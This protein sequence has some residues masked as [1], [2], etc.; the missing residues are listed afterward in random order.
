MKAKEKEKEELEE[1]KIIKV[2][3]KKEDIKKKE[4]DKMEEETNIYNNAKT[5]NYGDLVIIYETGDSIKYFTLEKG[6]RFQNK[7]GV[8]LHDD[9]Y[10]KNYG[11]KIYDTKEKKK[12]ISILSF[13]PNIWERC[14]NKMTQI[15]FN[16]DISLIMILLNISQ[17]SII[18]ESGTGSG[19]LSVNMSS[20]LSK[21]SGHLYT[22]EFNKE[23]A[24]K[25]KDL[26][27][28]LNLDKKITIT[29]RDVIQDG[30]MLDDKSLA[31]P[32]HKKCGSM[33]I[34]LPSPWLA[35]VHAK[36][37]MKSGAY[38][39]SFSPCI[40]QVNQTMKAMKENNF[41]ELR[42]FEC[43]YRTFSFAR[44][45]QVKMPV[46]GKRKKG[47]KIEFKDVDINITKNKCDM[48][49]HTGFLLFG[50]NKE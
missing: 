4:N 44:T 11:C 14:L 47:E 1:N 19:C 12:Y 30:F 18:Y 32:S 33:F 8:F 3:V 16:P 42:M 34:D 5:I 10:G 50:I 35:I 13:V 41:I 36:K 9:I 46:I 23:R 31:N 17:S 29:H 45:T 15:L 7:F 39:I 25:L 6:K 21:G 48:R 27:K 26:F 22:F 24:E 28:F 20:V 43:L 38:F 40:E 37:V 2:S 49:G